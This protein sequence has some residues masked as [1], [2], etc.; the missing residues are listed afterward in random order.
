MS[1]H[2]N[3]SFCH[4]TAFEIAVTLAFDLWPWKRV[5]LYLLTWWICV[6]SFI[7]IRPHIME[8]SHHTKIFVT[9]QWP[10][11]LTSSIGQQSFA[12]CDFGVWPLT[13][14]TFSAMTSRVL[15]ICV[16]F[17]WNPST[18]GYIAS[19]DISHHAIRL[20][21]PRS[22]LDLRRDQSS[23][24]FC[25][26]YVHCAEQSATTESHGTCSGNSWIDWVRFNVPSNTL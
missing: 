20:L 17:S 4:K 18:Y 15:N 19:C 24:K 7:E 1:S 10:W 3:V 11:P 16:N 13:L 8:I 14:K 9:S 22:D 6:L 23:A 26:L 2:Q 25:I 5:Q 21:W 12:F